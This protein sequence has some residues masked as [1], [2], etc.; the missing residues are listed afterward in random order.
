MAPV[1]AQH[2]HPKGECAQ[3]SW[4]MARELELMRGAPV[5]V[6]TLAAADPEARLAPLEQR[7]GLAL[8]PSR[9]VKLLVVPRR[10]P[11][12]DSY[13]GIL[14][15]R[16]PRSGGYRVSA[17]QRLWIEVVGPAGV[18]KSSR[19]AMQAGCEALRKSVAFPLEAE[20]DYW[21]ELSGSPT[22]DPDLLVTADR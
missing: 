1:P 22:P 12:A 19:F 6:A 9:R 18:V 10:E 20:T 13:A 11:A 14:R 7:L 15:L 4:D 17:S 16:V 2:D 21:I 8:L 5:A 3:F